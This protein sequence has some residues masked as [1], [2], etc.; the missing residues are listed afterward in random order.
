MPAAPHPRSDT[1]LPAMVRSRGSRKFVLS[2][3]AREQ[4]LQ[5]LD[6]PPKPNPALRSLMAGKAKKR[7]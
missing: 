2:D 5:A 3:R 6:H 1:P 7:G 4:F